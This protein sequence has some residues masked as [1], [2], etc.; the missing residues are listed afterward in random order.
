MESYELLAWYEL[1][2]EAGK[3][4]PILWME[5]GGFVSGDA[6]YGEVKRMADASWPDPM[7]DEG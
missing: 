1:V 4:L 6:V 5:E 3:S 2:E 7:G